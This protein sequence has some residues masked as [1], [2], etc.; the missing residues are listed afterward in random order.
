[1]KVAAIQYDIAWENRVPNHKRILELI[2]ASKLEPNT[3]VVLPEMF[4]T[5]FS[6]NPVK[7]IQS[8]ACESELFLSD[9]ASEYDCCVVGGVVGR[10]I[11]KKSSNEAA[12]FGTDG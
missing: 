7:T 6:M 10:G 12:V 9:V 1:M 3:L 11:T 8:E 2:T 4:D 5:G